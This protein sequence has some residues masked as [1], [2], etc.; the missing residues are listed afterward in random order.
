MAKVVSSK[1]NGETINQPLNACLVALTWILLPSAIG[2]FVLKS[3]TLSVFFEHGQLTSS[4]V[5]QALPIISVYCLSMILSAMSSLLVRGFHSLKDTKTLV[6]VGFVVLL[7]NILLALTFVRVFSILG[8]SI[9]IGL[10]MAN[11]IATIVQTLS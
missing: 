3:E 1:A 2:I 9:C 10:A 8:L 5:C 7:T 6:Y 11:A 4:D